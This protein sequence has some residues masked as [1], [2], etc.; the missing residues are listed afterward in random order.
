[1]TGVFG[2]VYFAMLNTGSV[3]VIF[4]AIVLSLIPHDMMYGPQAAL[5]AESFTG[6]PA[7]QRRLARLSA[8]LGHRRRA[9]AADRDLAV[10]HLPFGNAIAVYIAVCAVI[11]VVATA[12]MTDYT[13]KDI[14]A[15]G[16]HQ[17]RT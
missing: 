5:I 1:M 6:A 14:D 16:A 7:L 8:R 3:P 10:R 2:F 17:R 9:G 15:E 11:S 12:L 13:G 4:L